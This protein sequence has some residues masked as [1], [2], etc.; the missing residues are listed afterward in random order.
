MVK[1]TK[2]QIFL[3]KSSIDIKFCH[4]ENAHLAPGELFLEARQVARGTPARGRPVL[5]SAKAEGRWREKSSLGHGRCVGQ[6]REPWAGAG[7]GAGAALGLMGHT[8]WKLPTRRALE[9]AGHFLRP[10]A[11]KTHMET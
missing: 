4:E 10:C 9:S 11:L 6:K 2:L 7:A 8:C 3:R 1:T 5:C